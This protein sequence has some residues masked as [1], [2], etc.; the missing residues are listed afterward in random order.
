RLADQCENGDTFGTL[1]SALVIN[2]LNLRSVLR[3]SSPNSSLKRA[4]IS[5]RALRKIR[6]VGMSRGVLGLAA[7]AAAGLSVAVFF[8]LSS[9][10]PLHT[11]GPLIPGRALAPQ[12]MMQFLSDEHAVLEDVAQEQAPGESSAPDHLTGEFWAPEQWAP[13]PGSFEPLVAEPAEP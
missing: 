10:Q 9:S 8:G 1:F 7:L 4:F 13:R 2:P 5:T 3:M 12:P 6:R 11:A